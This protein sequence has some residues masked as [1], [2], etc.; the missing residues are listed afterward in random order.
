MSEHLSLYEIKKLIHEELERC[1]VKVPVE[2]KF[3]YSFTGNP[4]KCKK[5]V[6]LVQGD[7]KRAIY[8][9]KSSNDYHTADYYDLLFAVDTDGAPVCIPVPIANR[10]F[11][12]INPMECRTIMTGAVYEDIY[13]KYYESGQL[14]F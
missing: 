14:P 12:F 3:D 6:R 7:W 8:V 4:D 2:E 11:G 9:K 13:R 10:L 1:G 5:F